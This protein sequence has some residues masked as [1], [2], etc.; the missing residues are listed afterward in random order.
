MMADRRRLAVTIFRPR[1]S[2]AV[3]NSDTV[4]A[5]AGSAVARNFRAPGGEQFPVVLIGAR[6]LRA[7]ADPDNSC[8]F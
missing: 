7:R 2:W 4:S 5:D 8:R 6:V 1:V 3:K